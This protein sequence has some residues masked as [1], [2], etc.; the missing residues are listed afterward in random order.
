MATIRIGISGWR[1][2]PW[3]GIFYPPGLVQRR[4]LEFASRAFASIEI[5]G[6][7]YALQ[8]PQSYARWYDETPDDF[9]FSVKAPR[10]VT[11]VLRLKNAEAA[12]ANFLASG[13]LCLKQ[14]LG[15]ILWQF[16]P[17]LRYDEERFERFFAQLP[18][19]TAEASRIA[20]K[21]EAWMHERSA[22]ATDRDRPLRHA[23]EIRHPSFAQPAFIALLRR[24]GIALVVA[25]TAGKWP[26]LE[27]VTAGFVYLRLHGDEQL[28]ASGYTDA[29]LDRWASRIRGW[30]AGRE[31][32]DA[33]HAGEPL[34]AAKVERDVYCY[35]DNDIKVRAPF[36]AERLREKLGIA[37]ADAAFTFPDRKALAQVA[38]VVAEVP[39]PW[40][41]RPARAEANDEP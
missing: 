30:A 32:A 25:D 14:K 23:V 17:F 27:D 34:S 11:H 33:Q 22:V 13:V 6:S 4:E 31:P 18:A 1:Y 28:Y 38:D 41:R 8:T 12:L 26:C 10:Y 39:R 20:R 40:R 35:F 19:T 21:H 7:F 5:N 16:P 36:D 9:V 15:P 3:R 2:A 29:A 24:F 37:R